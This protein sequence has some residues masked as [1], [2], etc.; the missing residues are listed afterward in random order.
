MSTNASLVMRERSRGNFMWRGGEGSTT[1][2]V[3][4]LVIPA[5]PGAKPWAPHLTRPISRRFC[6]RLRAAGMIL[7]AYSPAI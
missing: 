7:K 3:S 2:S 4:S 5:N 1:A 6:R